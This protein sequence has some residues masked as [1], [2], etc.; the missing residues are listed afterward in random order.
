M[1]R[2][3]EVVTLGA[4][5]TAAGTMSVLTARPALAA[6]AQRG[7]DP[8]PALQEANLSA[9][10]LDSIENRLPFHSVRLLWEAAAQMT[11]DRSFGIH[12]A[13]TLP[14]GAFD[15][16]DHVMSAAATVGEGFSRLTRYIP[17]LHDDSSLRLVVEPGYGRIVR[18]VPLSAPQ[19][20]EFSMSLLLVRSRQSTGSEWKPE[21]VIFPHERLGD[22]GELRRLF[23]CPVLF[24]KKEAGLHFPASVL[25]LPH[26]RADSRLLDVLCRYADSLLG[27]LPPRGSLLARVSSTVARQMGRELPTLSTT[28]AAVRLPERTLQRRLATEGT[29]HSA[30]VDDVR[31]S[32]ALKY[33]GDASISVAEIAYLLHFT[34]STAFHRAFKRWTGEPPS[35]YRRELYGSTRT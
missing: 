6:L 5:M 22:E 25:A 34:D 3:T 8:G 35:H 20:D 26:V 16:F 4:M 2:A 19:Y 21:S 14:T 11:G 28:A 31:R 32:L 33:L 10:V 9:G 1:P 17:L 15:V 29:S 18:R 27:N 23:G 24:G 7:I 13:E 12:V 30:I